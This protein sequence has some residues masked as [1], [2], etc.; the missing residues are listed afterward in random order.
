MGISSP[1]IGSNLDVNSIVSQLMAVEQQ[2]LTDLARKEAGIQSKIAAFGSLS[3]ALGTFQSALSN[4]TD[5]AKF[6]TVNATAADTDILKGTATTQA[7]SGT[8]NV[9][10]TQLAQAQTVVTAGQASSTA[11]IGDGAKTTLTFT[12]GT[13]SG[14]KL[15]N[16]V[17]VSDPTATPNA[18]AFAADTTKVAGSVVIDSSNNTLQGIR[19]AINK[20][21]LGVTA[22]VVSDGSASP[23]HLVLTSN[24]TGAASSMQVA[25]ARDPLAPADTSMS[26]LLSY[27]PAGTQNMT[28]TSVA[29]DTKLTVNG[30]AIT[31]SGTSISGAIQ[32][33]TMDVSKIGTTSLTVARDSSSVTNNVNSF[34]KA[35]N[36]LN[37]TMA[38]LTK[39]DSS[40]KTGGPL[41][42]DSTVMTIQS[43]LRNMLGGRMPNATGSYDNLMAVGITFQKDGT[44]AVDS[45]K[46]SKAISDN[47]DSVA[48][49]FSSQGTA[50]DSLVSFTSAG[51][52]TAT[53]TF[54]V[55]VNALATK[56]SAVATA[57]P[58]STTV[59]AGTNDELSITLNGV[60][61]SITLAPGN[62][63]SSTLASALQSQINGTSELLKA[64]LSV[65]VSAD[66]SGILSVTTN[67]YGADAKVQLG[68][69][70]QN[71]LFPGDTETAGTDVNGT[72]NGA[73]ATGSGQ[74]LSTGDG[75]KIQVNGGTA[76]ADRGSVSFARGF[77]ELVS[78]MVDTFKG[79]GGM[80][81]GSTD[82]LQATI[83]TIGQQRDTINTQLADTEKRYRAQFTALDTAIAQM[84]STSQYLTQQLASIAANR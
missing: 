57:A 53:G 37:T 13:I 72:I 41:L 55:H 77:A 51:A 5:P 25:V 79:T 60:S 74:Y 49:L 45:S 9:D 47:P 62:Y 15:Q 27:D 8:Y 40:T 23:Y 21:N 42:G 6:Q 52:S 7:V 10:V 78:N 16:G 58:T 54:A 48:A 39:Y 18:P 3:G 63:T 12:F 66:A 64:G 35:Y 14:G 61:T 75:L 50:T 38:N 34:V 22:T 36:D 29:Q 80:I 76:P 71:I 2:P 19:D 70:A 68:G 1:G 65:A 44:L 56:G 20:A 33:V 28:Q 59:V 83:K 82:G 24:A 46:L 31:G 4:L 67:A 73:I 17:Y 26:S 32:G 43:Q 81:T 30:I 11:A 69:S 84:N